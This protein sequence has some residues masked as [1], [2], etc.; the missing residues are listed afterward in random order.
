MRLSFLTH[1]F[2]WV[3]INSHSRLI[4]RLIQNI[5]PDHT[6]DMNADNL[7]IPN[8]TRLWETVLICGCCLHRWDDGHQRVLWRR[9]WS[10]VLLSSQPHRRAQGESDD[11]SVG[12]IHLWNKQAG[13][14]KSVVL[15]SWC[16]CVHVIP[17][18]DA[19]SGQFASRQHD[20][21]L[22]QHLPDRGDQGAVESKSCSGSFL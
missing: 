18:Q 2:L 6:A 17:D 8:L 19:G 20:V 3:R 1:L 5:N 16:V 13:K 21:Q 15:T 11:L 22:H 12:L 4:T 7:V 10:H 14:V 9:V